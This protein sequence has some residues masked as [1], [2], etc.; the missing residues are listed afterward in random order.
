MTTLLTML[1]VPGSEK[2][3]LSHIPEAQSDACILDLEDAVAIDAKPR[4][5][6]LAAS[7]LTEMGDEHRLWVRVNGVDSGMLLE[8]LDTVVI[9]GLAGIDLPK[10]HGPRDI[11]IA[12]WLIGHWEERRGL[13]AGSVKIMATIESA[14]G[15]ANVHQIAMA[16]DR[17]R[18]LCFGAGDF[19]LDIGIDWPLPHGGGS[20]AILA[21]KVQL[22]LASRAA[23]LEPPHDAVFPNYLD[24][25]GLRDEA[26][27][28]RDIGFLGK[29]VIH[30]SQ[31]DVVRE[32]FTP[33]D[34]QLER[35]RRIVDAFERAEHDGVAAVAFEGQ[36]VDYPVVQR[37]RMLVQL[38][39][40]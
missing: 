17:L 38:A 13:R 3:K 40:R 34:V 1:F 27:V 32:V 4:A 6:E 21:A 15:V 37:A 16:S 28:A 29:H 2:R 22:V 25:A 31:I 8:D 12:D 10:V 19:S 36:L 7:T 9:G 33:S 5:R 26:I 11:Q 23:G 30:P 39:Q 35:A 24:A 20:P 18:V 14:A